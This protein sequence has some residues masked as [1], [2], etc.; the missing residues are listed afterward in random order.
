MIN[1]IRLVLPALLLLATVFGAG[2][3]AIA[4]DRVDALPEVRDASSARFDLAL[5]LNDE[6]LIVGKGEVASA[7]RAHFVLKLLD[8]DGSVAATLEV[9]LFDNNVYVREDADPQWYVTDISTV[10]VADPVAAPAVDVEAAPISSIGAKEIAGVLTNQYQVWISGENLGN[11]TGDIDHIAL[12]FFVGQQVNY[13]YQYQI[14][15]F[16]TDPDL[17]DLKL[18]EV[19]RL[20]DFNDP[21]IV[22]GAP[23]NAIPAPTPTAA[24]LL[25]RLRNGG[26]LST[27]ATPLSTPQLRELTLKH[28]A[29]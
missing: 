22:V 18:E 28:F 20:Y 15:S 9:V 25:P 19:T 13:L 3:R 7:T 2:S 29:R 12:D 8:V 5:A 14:S 17:G 23:A 10:P 1:R 6:Q 16:L 4:A 21:S 11:E 27:L 26:L 24:G